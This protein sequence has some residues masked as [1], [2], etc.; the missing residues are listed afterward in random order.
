MGRKTEYLIRKFN[1]ISSLRNM[2]KEPKK[3]FMKVRRKEIIIAFLKS[4]V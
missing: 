1:L 3:K 2:R 4:F